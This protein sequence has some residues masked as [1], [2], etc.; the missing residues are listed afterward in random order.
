M[1]NREITCL[2]KWSPKNTASE[3]LGENV[4]PSEPSPNTFS[5]HSTHLERFTVSSAICDLHF[6][7]LFCLHRELWYTLLNFPQFEHF[8]AVL[9]YKASETSQV[10]PMWILWWRVPTFLCLFPLLT[11]QITFFNKHV[12]E[13]GPIS[14]LPP[15]CFF[16]SSTLMCY[17]FSVSSCFM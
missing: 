12:L 6:K 17:I 8:N 4:W 13:T 9:R 5:Q 3:I 7:L 14:T 10:M 15:S 11:P 2:T 1:L 16:S